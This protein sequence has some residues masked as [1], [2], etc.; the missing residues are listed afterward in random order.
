M[1]LHHIGK[2]WFKVGHTLQLVAFASIIE[3]NIAFS[4]TKWF[5][6]FRFKV[7]QSLTIAAIFF[8]FDAKVHAVCSSCWARAELSEQMSANCERLS[9][10]SRRMQSLL[11]ISNNE[12]LTDAGYQAVQT[13]LDTLSNEIVGIQQGLVGLAEQIANAGECECDSPEHDNEP[14][15]FDYPPADE[16]PIDYEPTWEDVYGEGHPTEYS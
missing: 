1:I 6:S 15:P 12:E 16:G 7:V 10:I 14:E 3:G 4:L 2:K 9:D 11:D 13:S 5:R 8:C